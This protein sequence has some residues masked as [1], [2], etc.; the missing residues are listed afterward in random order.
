[1]ACKEHLKQIS[2]STTSKKQQLKKSTSDTKQTHSQG[3]KKVTYSSFQGASWVSAFSG[4]EAEVK[5]RHYSPKTLKSYTHWLRKFQTFTKSKPL[6]ILNDTDIK[7]FLT[8]LAVKQNASASTQNQAFNALLFIYRHVLKKEPGD[9]KN[10]VRAQKTQYI[11]DV[12]SRD[13][14]DSILQNL[15]LPYELVIKLLYGCGLRLFECLKLRIQNFNFDTGILTINDGKGKKNRTVPIPQVLVPD[16]KKQVEHLK[17]VYLED[18]KSGYDGYAPHMH[19][20]FLHFHDHSLQLEASG[21]H[22]E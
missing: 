9:I 5:L 2:I 14:I 13:E 10:T 20:F 11:P 7:E 4:L 19:E 18:L 17:T 22:L 16:L 3:Q 6:D 15:S 8:F 12:L 1:M 21:S